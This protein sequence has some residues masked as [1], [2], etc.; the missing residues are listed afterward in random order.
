MKFVKI[1]K[2]GLRVLFLTALVIF[3]RCT[4]E[5]SETEKGIDKKTE[6]NQK[7]LLQL[8]NSYRAS[9]CDCGSEGYFSSTTPVVWN[10]QLEQAA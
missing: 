4:K 1:S 7:L 10:A 2:N 3:G 6:I 5:V 9:G 8:V